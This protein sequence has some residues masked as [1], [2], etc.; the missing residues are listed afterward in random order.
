MVEEPN[1]WNVFGG[2][3]S[4]LLRGGTWFNREMR[5]YAPKAL[6]DTVHH[7]TREAVAVA[8]AGGTTTQQATVVRTTAPADAP[9]TAP[10]PGA[11]DE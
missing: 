6:R 1:F 3:L 11:W 7:A 9:A 2:W 5:S 4:N 10:L 8:A